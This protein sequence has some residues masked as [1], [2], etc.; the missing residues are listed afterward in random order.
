MTIEWID[1]ILDT[2]LIEYDDDVQI[3]FWSLE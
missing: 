1:Y 3:T 2:H